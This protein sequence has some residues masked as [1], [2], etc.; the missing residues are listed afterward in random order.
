MKESIL[1]NIDTKLEI[2]TSS[3][4]NPNTIRLF[5]K[6]VYLFLFLNTLML[7]PQAEQFWG[8]NIYA[9]KLAINTLSNILTNLLNY[10]YFKSYYL[11]FVFAQLTLLLIAFFGKNQRFV[12]ILVYFISFNLYSKAYVIQNGGTN[13]IMLLLLYSLFMSE[14]ENKPN[15]KLSKWD[16]LKN[17]TTNIAFSMARI[18]VI[19]VYAVAGI[20]KLSGQLWL[21]GEGVYYSMNV[22]AYSHPW[23]QKYI[24]S[25][26]LIQY[27]G[28]YF[29]L[30][31]QVT[32]PIL[33]CFSKTRRPILFLGTIL[34]VLIIFFMGLT[35]FGIAMI[36][37]YTVFY[38]ESESSK[39]IDT[40]KNFFKSKK[41]K[42][43][44]E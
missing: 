2:L 23:V 8:Q 10:E 26:D 29:T 4:T 42:T 32:F 15:T 43:S 22:D 24:C 28:S 27:F 41:L 19:L 5:K 3:I 13:L 1:K 21:K 33:V 7:L 20:Y 40:F 14:D 39:T 6:S 17:V 38:T 16:Y 12:G 25:N 37:A 11:Y 18:Q 34:H 35:D 9:R 30:I 31:V 44:L 36:V